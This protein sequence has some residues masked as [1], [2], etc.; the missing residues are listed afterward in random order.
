MKGPPPFG[1]RAQFAQPWNRAGPVRPRALAVPYVPARA[2]SLRGAWGLLR[3][4]HHHLAHHA[5]AVV[6]HAVVIVGSRLLEG[7]AEARGIGGQRI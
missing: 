1:S 4:R 5:E 6:E 2:W 3:R 7:G